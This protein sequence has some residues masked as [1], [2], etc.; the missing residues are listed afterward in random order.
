MH[1]VEE[2]ALAC[3]DEAN[4]SMAARAYWRLF[5][6]GKWSELTRDVPQQQPR[7]MCREGGGAPRLIGAWQPG[8]APG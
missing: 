1:L 5:S 2:D 3:Q 7:A 6:R 4:A 8:G